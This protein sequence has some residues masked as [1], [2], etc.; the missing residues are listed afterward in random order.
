[1]LM[2]DTGDEELTDA[3]G[4]DRCADAGTM[5]DALIDRDLPRRPFRLLCYECCRRVEHL[6]PVGAFRPAIPLIRA[7]AEGLLSDADREAARARI[8]AAILADPALRAAVRGGPELAAARA[9]LAVSFALWD[10]IR[11]NHGPAEGAVYVLNHATTAAALARGTYEQLGHERWH[12]ARK[13]ESR[14]Q[15]DIIR[16]LFSN[17]FQAA[18]PRS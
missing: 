8:D 11:N 10:D 17:P 3:G 4:W 5:L 2:A 14:A 15:A 13:A 18:P 7:W 9:A 6:L 12:D 1:M 16:A